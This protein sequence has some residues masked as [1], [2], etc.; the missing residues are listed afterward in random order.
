MQV[1]SLTWWKTAIQRSIEHI[2]YETFS[3]DILLTNSCNLK[4][5]YCSRWCNI[6]KNIQF[7]KTEDA[8][9]DMLHIFEYAK[10]KRCC[11]GGGEPTIHPRH[12]RFT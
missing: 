10:I 11:L 12:H 2:K 1:G 3:Y 8:I 9:S 5:K 4:C 6:T 7:Y